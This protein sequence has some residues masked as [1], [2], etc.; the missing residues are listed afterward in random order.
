MK[1]ATITLHDTDNCGS[2]LQAFALQ[3]FML[4]QGFD[5]QIID[6][7][8]AY[9]KNNGHPLKTLI[10]KIVFAKESKCRNEKFEIF[11]N[12]YLQLTRQRYR[13][14]GQLKNKPPQADCYIVGSDQLWNTMYMCGRDPAFYLDFGKKNKIAYAVSMGRDNISEDN[15]KM[16]QKYAE[17]FKW[18]SVREK[19]SIEQMSKWIKKPIYHVCDPVMLNTVECYDVVRGKRIINEDYILVY[20]AQ[21]VDIELLVKYVSIV[22]EKLKAKVVFIGTYRNKI[23]CDYHI[24][25]MAP[26]EFLSLIYNAGYIISNSFHATLFSMLY[27]KQFA[28]ILPPQNSIRIT[29]LLQTVGEKKRIVTFENLYKIKDLSVEDYEMIENR[30][31]VFGEYSKE[32]F[33][34][35]L[36]NVACNCE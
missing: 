4:R 8:P 20:L 2:S 13:Y 27:K 29:D 16:L 1:T 3:Q 12:K 18:I 7:V 30:L 33:L 32:I 14:L 5:N 9:A 17:D 22:R 34:E 10:R 36:Q 19:A 11:V 31:R 26:S 24:R 35:Q 28:V 6:Y 15:V 21:S 25:D 23:G